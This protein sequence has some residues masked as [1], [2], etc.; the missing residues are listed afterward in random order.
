MR[1]FFKW[2]A[3]VIGS[4]LALAVIFTVVFLVIPL[5]QSVKNLQE[6][7]DTA[8]VPAVTQAADVPTAAAAP[9]TTAAA[10]EAVTAAPENA[11][12]AQEAAQ[13]TEFDIYRTG[14]FY[15]KGTVTDEDG[16]TNPM[17]LA[18]TDGSVYMLT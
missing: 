1:Q 13:T 15:V 2:S 18:I 14:K 12:P 4:L 10:P 5:S 8:S 7:K 3:I 17:E 9:D 16:Q 6:Q 11:A